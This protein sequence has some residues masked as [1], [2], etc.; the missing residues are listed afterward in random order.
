MSYRKRRVRK[1]GY[2]AFVHHSHHS[3]KSEAKRDAKNIRDAGYPARVTK[4][5]R[6]YDVW[7][8]PAQGGIYRRRKY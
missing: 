6:G 8:D 5:K 2:H 3:N 1:F 4:A 7:W